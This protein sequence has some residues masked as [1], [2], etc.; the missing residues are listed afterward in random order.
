VSERFEIERGWV[1]LL[2]GTL[3]SDGGTVP[4]TPIEVAVLAVLH[5]RAPDPISRDALLVEAWGYS[6]KTRSRTVPVTIQRLRA[7]I[8]VEPSAPR[9]IVTVRGRGYALHLKSQA[10]ADPD[11]PPDPVTAESP[12]GRQDVLD[13]LATVA[14]DGHRFVTLVGPGGMGKTTVARHW[15]AETGAV[16]VDLLG[17]RPTMALRRRLRAALGVDDAIADGETALR[18]G[19]RAVDHLVLDNAE[20]LDA[21]AVSALGALIREHPHLQVLVTSQRP[22]RLPEERRVLLGELDEGA[23]RVLVNAARRRAG[24]DPATDAQ[25]ATLWEAVGG[26]PLAL[27]MLAPMLDW[28]DAGVGALIETPGAPSESHHETVAAAMRRTLEGVRED[29][30]TALLATGCFGRPVSPVDLAR[31]AGIE[32]PACLAAVAELRERGLIRVANGRI[33]SIALVDTLVQNATGSLAERRATCAQRHVAWVLEPTRSLPTLR[34]HQRELERA[35]DAARDR[36]LLEVTVRLQDV[37]VQIGPM[38]DLR[39]TTTV[40][41]QR[42]PAALAPHGAV[43]DVTARAHTGQQ[44][45]VDVLATTIRQIAADDAVWTVRGLGSLCVVQTWSGMDDAVPV[46]RQLL[47]MLDDPEVRRSIDPIDHIEALQR[48]GYA[49]ARGGFEAEAVP[50]LDA[51]IQRA[52]TVD[53]GRAIESLITRGWTAGLDVAGLERLDALLRQHRDGLGRLQATLCAAQVGLLWLDAGAQ[54]IGLERLQ[55]E[56]ALLDPHHPVAAANLRI[57]MLIRL[58]LQPDAAR[59]VL[60]ALPA[61]GA[62]AQLELLEALVERDPDRVAACPDPNLRALGMAFLAGEPLPDVGDWP[63]T[64]RG[65]LTARRLD[66]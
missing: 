11:L 18:A 1:D 34:A 4:L 51:A 16:W 64:R 49:L 43:V 54:G 3:R 9:T 52:L 14:R 23:A 8:E 63:E 61:D 24:L 38:D 50:I 30:L 10:D 15:R 7:K 58:V 59:D 57:R 44:V 28:L 56:L 27:S 13:A 60:A 36:D 29:A 25:L 26:V 6:P 32:L 21:D 33:Q 19:L 39:A 55:H 47:S 53:P 41:L 66:H 2:E 31:V 22:L 5:D 12:I 42:L 62:D 17:A 46:A 40:A 65:L 35:F 48:A 20:D 37:L 45:P